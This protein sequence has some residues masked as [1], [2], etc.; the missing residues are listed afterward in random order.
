MLS[1]IIS[2]SRISDNIWNFSVPI[3]NKLC[4][5]LTF[6]ECIIHN[7]PITLYVIVAIKHTIVKLNV[8]SV[9]FLYDTN[10]DHWMFFPHHIWFGL[11]YFKTINPVL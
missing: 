5:F 3:K 1:Q 6:V 9:Y 8:V 4:E 10:Y 7:H 2:V 11:P